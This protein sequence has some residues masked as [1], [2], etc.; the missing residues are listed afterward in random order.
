MKTLS[1]VFRAL[2]G[3]NIRYYALLSGCCLFSVLLITAYSCMM[4]SPTVLSVLPEGGDSRKQVM[5]IFAMAVVGYAVFTTYASGLFFRYKSYETGVLMALG[6][7][8]RKI[9]EQLTRELALISFGSC[10]LGALLGAPLAFVIWQLFRM[11]MVD[12]EEMPLRF[13]P[14]A[15]SYALAFSVFVIAMLFFML[16]RFLKRTNIMDVVQES[17]KSKP[18]KAVPIWY[19]PLGISLL[20]GGFLLGYLAPS[21]CIDVLQ[22]Y[23]PDG[24]TAPLYIPVFWFVYD[25]AAHRRKRLAPGK[26][27]I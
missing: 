18:I 1:Q 4:R 17:R 16:S 7:S 2:R 6:A 8:K 24:L 27:P 11:V 5:M 19:G 21:F 15:Y 12:S 10:S 3:K 23:P 22:W 20:A 9:K 25:T 26:E 13:D 14:W